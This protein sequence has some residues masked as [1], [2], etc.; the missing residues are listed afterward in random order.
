M[1]FSMCLGLVL[2]VLG[3]MLLLPPMQ[4]RAR[5]RNMRL[6]VTTPFFHMLVGF[7]TFMLGVYDLR[8]S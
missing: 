6:V 2:Y 1:N 8:L 3:A 4:R 5:E 7:L